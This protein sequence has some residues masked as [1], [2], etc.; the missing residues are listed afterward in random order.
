MIWEVRGAQLV[1]RIEV[2]GT[3]FAII[4]WPNVIS[5]DKYRKIPEEMRNDSSFTSYNAPLVVIFV[6]V[7]VVIV[8]VR[9][10]L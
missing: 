4:T 8:A 2:Q 1:F 3:A 9:K 10:Q 5:L 7:A 6:S